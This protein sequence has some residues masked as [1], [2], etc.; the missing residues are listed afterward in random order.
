MIA[1]T[2]FCALARNDGITAGL[3]GAD[4]IPSSSSRIFFGFTESVRYVSAIIFTVID[5]HL[6]IRFSFVDIVW[7]QFSV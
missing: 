6:T 4:Q 2:V 1:K 7:R 3:T 5:V